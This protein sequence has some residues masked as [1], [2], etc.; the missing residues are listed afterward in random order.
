VLVVV[1]VDEGAVTLLPPQPAQ[2]QAATVNML[3]RRIRIRTRGL[4]P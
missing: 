4:I 2:N 1:D 3:L